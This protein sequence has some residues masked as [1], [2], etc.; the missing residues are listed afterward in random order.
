M[1]PNDYVV[2]DHTANFRVQAAKGCT[3]RTICQRLHNYS[4]QQM[5][6]PPL[7]SEPFQQLGIS[8]EIQARGARPAQ[9]V[10][11]R[12]LD[13]GVVTSSPHTRRREYL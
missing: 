13:L 3:I 4:E 9:L 10:E 1:C 12:T 11:H 7:R 5:R 6:C 2:A 8:L